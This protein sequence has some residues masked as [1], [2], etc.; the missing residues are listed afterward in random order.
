MIKSFSCKETAKI[1]ER[2]ISL[3][4]PHDLQKVALRKLWMIDAAENINDLR[5]PPSNHLE[6]LKITGSK[7]YSIRLNK[8]WRITFQWI[9]NNAY[10]V[11]IIDYH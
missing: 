10:E 3:A 9:D 7:T 4:L 5:I 1:F 6:K 11:Q 2:E 8:Q